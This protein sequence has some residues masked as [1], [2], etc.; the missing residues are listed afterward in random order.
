MFKEEIDDAIL[1]D[2]IRKELL[3]DVYTT[4]RELPRQC[5]KIISMLYRE[6]KGFREI[7]QEMD[8]SISTIKNQK[9]RGIVLVRKKLGLAV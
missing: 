2:M 1:E 6:G 3:R 5:K 4:I 8:L 9:E 7:A